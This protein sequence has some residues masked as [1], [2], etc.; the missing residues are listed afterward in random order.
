M[1]KY[2]VSFRTEVTQAFQFLVDQRG[3][4]GPSYSELLLPAVRYRGAGLTISIYFHDDTRDGAGK[5][6]SVS[7]SLETANGSAKAELDELVEAAV[8]APRHR[9]DWKAHTADAMRSTL[10]DDA[11]W[12]RRPMPILQAP[13]ALDTIRNANR[14]ETDK[15]GNTKRR[16][17]NIKWKY[18]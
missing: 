10:D 1:C 7:I 4:D 17:R 3:L 9:V 2:P 6:I 8:F 12:V 14:H 18:N 15:A 16:P 11:K 13:D 5:R